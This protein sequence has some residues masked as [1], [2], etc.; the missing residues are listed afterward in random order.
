MVHREHSWQHIN[1]CSNSTCCG[2]VISDF[3]YPCRGDIQYVDGPPTSEVTPVHYCDVKM[4]VMASQIT[5]HTIVYSTVYSGANQRKH[6]S[7]TSL[8]FVWGIHRWPVNSPHKGPVTRKMFPF[9]YVIMHYQVHLAI[10]TKVTLMVMNDQL[11]PLSFYVYR[12]SHSWD[13]AVSN[14]DLEARLKPKVIWMGLV[15][16]QGPIVGPISNWFTSFWFHTNQIYNPWNT[17]ISKFNLENPRSRSWVSQ[18]SRSHYSS[19]LIYWRMI[20][21]I[22]ISDQKSF[23]PR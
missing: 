2:I 22:H 14:F 21:F 3:S 7:S 6:R 1:C 5:S 9:D 15:K 19:S 16:G 17:A 23:E 13:E 12:P 11:T 10:D 18:K 8:A 20:F 4:G